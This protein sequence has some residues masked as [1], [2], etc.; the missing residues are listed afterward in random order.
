MSICLIGKSCSG[1]DTVLKELLKLGYEKVVTYTTRPKR[2]DEINGV[3]YNF[4]S[5]EEFFYMTV[6]EKFAEWRE[7]KTNNGVWY[8]GSTIES[9]KNSNKKVV[10]LT[11]EGCDNLRK[12]FFY[13]NNI[14]TIYLSAS[15][16]VIKKR[17][18]QRIKQSGEDKK[19]LKRRYRADKKDFQF[20]KADYVIDTSDKTPIEIARKCMLYDI[21]NE[22]V[23]GNE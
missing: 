1:K 22:N 9:F 17:M 5:D 16:K 3:S 12:K 18:K 23:G 2:S 21:Y 20:V 15:N 8:Y 10:I 6:T 4:I 19:E 13:L 7:Y 14:V 11:P